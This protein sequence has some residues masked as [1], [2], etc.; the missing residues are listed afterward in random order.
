MV[1]ESEKKCP[2]PTTNPSFQNFMTPTFP[3]FP[4]PT[5]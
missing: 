1:A 2:T 3:K 4:T 5:P